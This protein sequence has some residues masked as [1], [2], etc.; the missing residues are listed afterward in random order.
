M[1]PVVEHALLSVHPGAE[2]DFE[3]AF[4][5]ARMIPAQA[6]GFRS[7]RLL[8]GVETPTEYRLLIEWDS[9]EDHMVGFRSSALY[10]RW[11]ALL[12]PHY[13]APPEVCH[14]TEVGG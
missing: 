14:G 4:A 8:R 6:P 10:E 1:P 11:S 13:S 3:R 12:R 2:A 5:V 9:V 7:L